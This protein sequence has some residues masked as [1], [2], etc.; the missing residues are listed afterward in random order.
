MTVTYSLHEAKAKLSELVSLAETGE[1]IQIT[2]HGK[3]VA[4][5]TGA[6]SEPRRPGGGRGTFKLI[7]EWDFTDEEI[8]EMF[9]GPIEPSVLVEPSPGEP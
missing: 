6:A 2:R 1:T 8:E 5:L 4:Q 9:Y 3:V 7:G